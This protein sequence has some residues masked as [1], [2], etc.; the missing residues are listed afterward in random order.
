MALIETVQDLAWTCMVVFDG[1]VPASLRAVTDGGTVRRSDAL[2]D[3]AQIEDAL[4]LAAIK[5]ETDDVGAMRECH[6]L[7]G[8]SRAIEIAFIAATAEEK[9]H[10]LALSTLQLA[11]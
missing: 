8:A 3:M 1:H 5:A 10:L 6:H 4:E 9:A 2:R 11:D 7:A